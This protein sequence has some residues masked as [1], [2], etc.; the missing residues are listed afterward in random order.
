MNSKKPPPVRWVVLFLPAIH[1]DSLPLRLVLDTTPPDFF[2][3]SFDEM[4][5]IVQDKVGT[6]DN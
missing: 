3:L 4:S 2:G 1:G 5:V 6:M